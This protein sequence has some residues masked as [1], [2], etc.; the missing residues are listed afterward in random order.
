[1]RRDVLRC[2]LRN[3]SGSPLSEGSYLSM[4]LWDGTRQGHSRP[5]VSLGELSRG[6]GKAK[7]RNDHVLPC[8]LVPWLMHSHAIAR[9]LLPQHLR[10]QPA[11]WARREPIPGEQRELSPL[12]G[13]PS[14]SGSR[15]QQ[16]AGQLR[17]QVVRLLSPPSEAL[18]GYVLRQFYQLDRNNQHSAFMC[19]R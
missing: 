11:Q 6:Q 3:M 18:C 8:L 12:G 1:M 13:E 16:I 19:R 10:Q 17:L 14:C 7:W 2:C 4:G 9:H 15:L 5:L